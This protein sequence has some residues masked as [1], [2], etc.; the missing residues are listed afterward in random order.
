[1]RVDR[2]AEVVAKAGK[3]EFAG[4]GAAADGIRCFEDGGL[5]TGA[6]QHD[7]RGQPIGSG[8]DDG[9]A[10]FR[11]EDNLRYFRRDAEETSRQ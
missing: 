4:A 5:A 1:M 10:L 9:S 8:A 7:R 11:G 3:R 6:S 2:G